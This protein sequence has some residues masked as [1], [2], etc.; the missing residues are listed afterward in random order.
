MPS[1]RTPDEIYIQ[2]EEYQSI[3]CPYLPPVS[4]ELRKSQGFPAASARGVEVGNF[5]NTGSPHAGS[6]SVHQMRVRLFIS[7]QQTA[8]A[9]CKSEP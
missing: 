7:C 2:K 9:K 6:N 4:L 1:L 5:A 3:I 8:V